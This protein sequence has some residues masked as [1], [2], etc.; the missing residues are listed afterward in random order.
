[1]TDELL[2]I[3]FLKYIFDTVVSHFRRWWHDG[4]EK[5]SVYTVGSQQ[6]TLQASMVMA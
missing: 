5:N 4:S 3:M 1:M 2:F 6:R